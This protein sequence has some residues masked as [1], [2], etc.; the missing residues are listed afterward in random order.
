MIFLKAEENKRSEETHPWVQTG[1]LV[2]Q[3]RADRPSQLGGVPQTHT[4]PSLPIGDQG[5]TQGSLLLQ[6]IHARRSRV[7]AHA[8]LRL[9]VATRPRSKAGP[10]RVLAG[11]AVVPGAVESH[12]N[13]ALHG[14]LHV[15]CLQDSVAGRPWATGCMFLKYE[16]Y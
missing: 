10:R 3:C 11:L 16:P 13:N 14:H 1:R 6:L 12:P 8:P 7:L 2:S 9:L 4:A 15:M 5:Q